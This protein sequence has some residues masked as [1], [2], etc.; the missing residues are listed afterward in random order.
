[1]CSGLGARIHSRGQHPQG[2]EQ[3]GVGCRDNAHS[4]SEVGEIPYPGW[5]SGICWGFFTLKPSSFPSQPQ[6]AAPGKLPGLAGAVWVRV[7]WRSCT[8]TT[9]FKGQSLTGT[10]SAL[11]DRGIF[12]EILKP[13]PQKKEMNLEDTSCSML[14]TKCPPKPCRDVT[15]FGGSLR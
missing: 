3:R 14:R 7:D 12:A 1:M 4:C 11:L 13:H 8:S 2:T 5:E 9:Q 10:L 15:T 6:A